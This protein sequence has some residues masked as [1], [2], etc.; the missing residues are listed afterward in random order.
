MVP[1][2]ACLEPVVRDYLPQLYLWDL[3]VNRK[4]GG[5]LRVPMRCH[6]SQLEIMMRDAKSKLP[7]CDFVKSCHFYKLGASF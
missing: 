5:L 1:Y 7:E 2:E 3:L 6:A 4:G